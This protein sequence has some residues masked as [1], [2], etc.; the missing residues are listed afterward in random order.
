MDI[1]NVLYVNM[2]PWSNSAPEIISNA[3]SQYRDWRRAWHMTAGEA[4]TVTDSWVQ[5]VCVWPCAAC[6]CLRRSD[7][8]GS[9][10]KCSDTLLCL[11]AVVS[12]SPPHPECSL[13]P[14]FLC[15]PLLQPFQGICLSCDDLLHPAN[16]LKIDSHQPVRRPSE[17]FSG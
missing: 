11:L 9:S 1:C 8:S 10:Q 4:T 3:C 17:G 15:F 12:V 16:L 5:Y 14:S 6:R 13:C 2:L 7:K